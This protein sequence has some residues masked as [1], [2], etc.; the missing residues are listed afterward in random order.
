M[1]LHIIKWIEQTVHSSLLFGTDN[2]FPL[3]QEEAGKVDEYHSP[4]QQSRQGAF[5]RADGV[6]QRGRPLVLVALQQSGQAE[7]EV[8][9]LNQEKI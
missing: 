1:I 8:A 2:K 9:E 7:V 3:L 6:R 5:V 4:H